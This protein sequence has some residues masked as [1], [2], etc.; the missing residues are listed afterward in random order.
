MNKSDTPEYAAWE[1]MKLRC[2]NPIYKNSH[3]YLGRGIIVCD[4]WLHDFDAFRKHIGDRPSK[5]Y[6]VDRINNDGNYEPGNVRWATWYV[7]AAN[8]RPNSG[9]K[10]K[11]GVPTTIFPYVSKNINRY[12]VRFSL[13]GKRI[14]AGYFYDINDAISAS[15]T[16]QYGYYGFNA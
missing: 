15:L 2:Y 5:D 12:R 9:Y 1:N 8:R 7:Q 3:N 11:D 6:S 10:R 13:D 14:T 16:V 4:E